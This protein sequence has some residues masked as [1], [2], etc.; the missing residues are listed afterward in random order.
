MIRATCH[1][2]F[3]V[4]FS[5][6]IPFFP[7]CLAVLWGRRTYKRE[8]N[9]TRIHTGMFLKSSSEEGGPRADEEVFQIWNVN[10]LLTSNKLVYDVR[11]QNF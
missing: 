8:Q 11:R 3:Q 10:V 5:I 4:I 1:K 9:R 7:G 6:P 2:A